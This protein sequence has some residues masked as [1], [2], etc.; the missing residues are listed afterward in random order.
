MTA[1]KAPQMRTR[2]ELS[3]GEPFHYFASSLAS[4]QVGRDLDALVRRMKSDGLAFN[5]WRVDLPETA[6][7]KINYF[8]PQVEPEKLHLVGFWDHVQ[9]EG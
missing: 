5:V 6:P 8:C 4:W 9:K 7:Y 1:R 2:C 3:N